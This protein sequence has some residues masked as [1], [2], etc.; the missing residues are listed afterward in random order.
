MGDA[1]VRKKSRNRLVVESGM[2]RNNAALNGE[3]EDVREAA[4]RDTLQIAKR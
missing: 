2:R 4:R 3:I 1:I